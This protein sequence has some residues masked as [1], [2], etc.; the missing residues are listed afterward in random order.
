MRGNYSDPTIQ[1]LIETLH[2]RF[3]VGL[4]GTNESLYSFYEPFESLFRKTINAPVVFETANYL[5]YKLD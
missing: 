2:I 3:F 4:K 5:V 1:A